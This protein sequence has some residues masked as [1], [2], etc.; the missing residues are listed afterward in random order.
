MEAPAVPVASQEAE[1]EGVTPPA[2]SDADA[3]AE[4]VGPSLPPEAVGVK[5]AGDEGED[6]AVP[7]ALLIRG[8]EAV[9]LAVGGKGEGVAEAPPLP[10]PLGEAERGGV[11][12]R[13]PLALGENEREGSGED[14]SGGERV[15]EREESGEIEPRAEGEGDGEMRGE[16]V[17]EAQGEGCSEGSVVALPPP[18]APPPV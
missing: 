14:E 3:A 17:A 6:V 12:L 5:L 10:L 1:E 9:P 8:G 2:G 4:V 16:A 11:S 7:L 13:L 15:G 18:P